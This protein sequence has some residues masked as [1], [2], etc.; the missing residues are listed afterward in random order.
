MTLKPSHPADALQSVDP[1]WSQVR[2]EAEA[3]VQSRAGG[4]ELRLCNRAQP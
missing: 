1:V 2:R 3:I 4:R